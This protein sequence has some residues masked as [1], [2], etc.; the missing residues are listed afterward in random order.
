[1]ESISVEQA[2]QLDQRTIQQIGISA[3]VLMERAALAIYADLLNGVSKLDNV[4]ILAGYG[5]NGGDALALARLLY[6]H[7]FNVSILHVGNPEHASYENQKQQVS[8]D[9][10]QIP[11]VD[12]NIYFDQFTLIVDGI[13][14]VGLSRIVSGNY[15]SIIEKVNQA[16][17]PVH[18]IDIPSGLNGDTGEPMGIAIHAETTSTLSYP[19][20]GMTTQ[21]AQKYVGQ[22][23]IDD[24]G[25]YK[26]NQSDIN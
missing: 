7:G 1:M 12:E 6:T 14:G 13:F 5:N 4:L 11:I 22:I 23:F 25:I 20:N 2:Q 26:T 15:H 16:N 9:Y 3:L 8:C 19:K 10:Y 24:I 21:Q 18:A 17:T